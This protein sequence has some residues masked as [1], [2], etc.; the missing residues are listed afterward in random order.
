MIPCSKPSITTK[1]RTY[2]HDAMSHADI[3]LGSYV[4]KFE[5]SWAEYNKMS[6][7]VACN[8]GTNAIYI[9]LLALG[10]GKGDEVIVPSYTMVATAWAVTYTGAKPVF[11]DCDK[12]LNIDV[13]LIEDAI[14]KKTKAI[15]PVHIYGRQCDMIEIKKIAV[16]HQLY[17][18]E[19]MAEAHG[20]QPEG[21][22]AC[23][24]FYG[25]KIITTGEGGM[26]LTNS[27]VWAKEMRLYANMYFDKD[28]TML[29][30]KVG[31][32]FRMT[33]LQA[34]V[35][36]GQVMRI[37]EILDKRDRL[38]FIYED[39]LKKKFIRPVRNVVWMYDIDC[40]DKQEEIKKALADAGIESR[41][42]FKPMEQQ[43]MYF[44]KHHFLLNSYKW[45][46]R[47]IYLPTYPDLKEEQ[48]KKI[49][50]IVNSFK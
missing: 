15:I 23:Y 45:S 30:P 7:G 28:R 3:G 49:C 19:D 44:D 1:E 41:Y 40:G 36:Y 21:D 25:N 39:Y 13:S 20:I 27:E 34:A 43:P 18:V 29:H 9:A 24:S 37:D 26:C 12:D 35:G 38:Q 11:I 17:I 42:G 22:I 16:K 10:I 14:S 31:H 33:N 50:E 32:N 2:V 6:H 48:I 8:S 5:D 4:K 46:K 47:I